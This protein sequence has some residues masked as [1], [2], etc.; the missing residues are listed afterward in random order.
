M[1]ALIDELAQMPGIGARSAERLAFYILK[2][3]SPDAL[4]LADAIRSVKENLH[5]CADCYNLSDAQ[6][7]ALCA[8]PKRDHTRVLVVEQPKD[9]I[10]LELTG[11]YKGLYHVL[12]GRLSPLDG[13]SPADLTIAQLLDRI[14]NPREDSPRIEEVILGLNPTVEGDGTALYLAD[15]L[16]KRR[17]TVSRLARGLPTGGMLEYANKAVL[18]DAIQ[19]RQSVE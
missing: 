19:G 10:A 15:E 18:A 11:M 3:E 8:D 12:M 6:R 9:L 2:S 13:I 14:D 7:C 1:R 16:R 5:H 17:I 4:R